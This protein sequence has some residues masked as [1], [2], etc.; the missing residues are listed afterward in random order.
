MKIIGLTGNSGS[1]KGAV[2]SVLSRNG[3]YVIDA[4]CIA[5]ENMKK[6][7]CAYDEILDCFG[8]EIIDSSGEIDRKKLGGIV[9]SDKKKLERLN[10]VT[11]K[12]ILHTIS[13]EINGIVKEPGEY[14][15]IVIDA[16]LLIETGLY[17]I[18]DE[19]WVVFADFERRIKRVMIRDGITKECAEMRFK[20]Q[21]D[22]HRMKNYAD[23]II[24]NNF[25]S[26]EELEKAVCSLLK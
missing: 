21:T 2:S 4:D 20:N 5:H 17:K 6:G 12:H 9:F 11:H 22:F 15:Y 14:K 10:E 1:G 8:L 7:G 26:I 18:A 25:D 3:G 24:E 23:V 19:V 16:P 13:S